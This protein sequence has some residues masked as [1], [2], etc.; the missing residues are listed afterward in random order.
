MEKKIPYSNHI[1]TYKFLYEI[2]SPLIG[3][4]KNKYMFKY[5]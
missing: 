5:M 4:Y 1:L 2:L 3:N